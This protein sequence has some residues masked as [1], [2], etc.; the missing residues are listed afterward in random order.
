MLGDL[1]VFILCLWSEGVAGGACV[2]V[3]CVCLCVHVVCV[4]A[5]VCVPVGEGREWKIGSQ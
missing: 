3:L 5:C 1:R 4:C 2:C